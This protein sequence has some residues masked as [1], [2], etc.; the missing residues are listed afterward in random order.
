MVISVISNYMKVI[1]PTLKTG[2]AGEGHANPLILQIAIRQMERTF[3]K[4]MERPFYGTLLQVPRNLLLYNLTQL[5]PS[6]LKYSSRQEGAV[7]IIFGRNCSSI[8][9]TSNA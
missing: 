3:T 7:G 8:F 5:N 1:V 6:T 2:A 4:E 9:I